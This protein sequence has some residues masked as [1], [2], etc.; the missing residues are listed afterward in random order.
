MTGWLIALFFSIYSRNWVLLGLILARFSF[1]CRHCWGQKQ[2]EKEWA[3]QA[4]AAWSEEKENQ[5]IKAMKERLRAKYR[6][7]GIYK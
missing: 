6:N 4:E 2:L 1:H 7:P 5:E 3:R